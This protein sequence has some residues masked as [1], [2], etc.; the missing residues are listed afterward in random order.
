MT[1]TVPISQ[2][3]A[4]VFPRLKKAGLP[5]D[6]VKSYRPISNLTFLSKVIEQI[7]AKQLLAYL[8]INSLIP[9]FQSGFRKR[10][11][12]ETAILRVNS[13]ICDGI[14]RGDVALLALLD[15]SATFDTVDHGILLERLSNSYGIVGSAHEWFISYLT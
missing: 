1:S 14:D 7:I 3:K 12:T 2:K 8:E 5:I 9:K 11:S 13:D 4:I 15:V 6:D 10:H